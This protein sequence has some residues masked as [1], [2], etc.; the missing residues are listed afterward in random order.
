MNI[1]VNKRNDTKMFLKYIFVLK[2]KQLFIVIYVNV[3]VK[4]IY[5]HKSSNNTQ[6]YY[7]KIPENQFSVP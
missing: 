1:L 7:G 5:S 6:F 4:R 2:P 3:C